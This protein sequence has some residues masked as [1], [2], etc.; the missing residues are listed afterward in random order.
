[1]RSGIE[2]HL[3]FQGPLLQLLEVP[4]PH[5]TTEDNADE[6]SRLMVTIDVTLQPF[7]SL[8][9]NSPVPCHGQHT[10]FACLAAPGSVPG[11]VSTIHLAP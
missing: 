2:A 11:L 3:G 1:M 6:D 5:S 7:S 9:A 4:A 10:A 8:Y